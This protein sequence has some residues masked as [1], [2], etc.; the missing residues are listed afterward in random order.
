MQP[1]QKEGRVQ[2]LGSATGGDWQFP[3]SPQDADV[4]VH[5]YACVLGGTRQKMELVWG[6]ILNN[7]LSLCKWW[8]RTENTLIFCISQTRQMFLSRKAVGHFPKSAW[9]REN[10]VCD[11][12]KLKSLHKWKGPRC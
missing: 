2:G 12:G 1:E 9:T 4:C 6:V 3:V 11:T 8:Q 10:G 5:V 7:L